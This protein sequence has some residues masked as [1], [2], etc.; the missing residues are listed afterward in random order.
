M[1]LIKY[2]LP[3][4]L[5]IIP[6]STFSQENPMKK[7]DDLLESQQPNAAQ[8]ELWK[9]IET[10]QAKNDHPTLIKAFPYFTR[11]LIPLEADERTELFENV[12][13]KTNELSEPSKSI[14]ELQLMQSLAYNFNIWFDYYGTNDLNDR[15][16]RHHFILER[17]QNLAQ[18]TSL[19]QSYRFKD[20][21]TALLTESKDTLYMYH[22]L[23]DYMAY[24]LIELYRSE[25]IRSGGNLKKLTTENTAWYSTATDFQ[26]LQFDKAS[27]TQSILGLYQIIEGN[28]KNDLN[29]LST[30]VYQRLQYL[31]STFNNKEAIKKAWKEEFDFFKQTAARSKFLFELAKIK[32]YKGKEYHY[33]NKPEVEGLIKEAHLQLTEEL[34]AF[35][36]TDFK[37]E[38]SGLISIIEHQE[39]K[40][41]FPQITTS[42]KKIPL[43]VSHRNYSTKTL[44]IYFMKEYDPSN[45]ISFREYIKKG[46]ANVVQTVNLELKNKDLFQERTTELLLDQLPQNGRYYI[47]A[48]DGAID[49]S[50]YAY[51]D[52]KW[53]DLKIS[54]SPFTISDIVA[55]STSANN[56][57]QVLVMDQKTGK[58]IKD[59]E[60]KIYYN[61]Y[62]RNLEGKIIAQGKTNQDGLFSVP[63]KENQSV[64][65]VVHYKDNVLKGARN[66]LYKN[67]NSKKIKQ[68]KLITDRSIYRPNQTV[69]FKGIAYEGKENEYSVSKG[70][71]VTITL[72]DASYQE[73][74]SE[75]FKTNEFGSIDGSIQIPE[76][77][78]LG[79]FT[80]IANST[81][82]GSNSSSISF[83]VEEYKRPTYEVKLNAPKEEAKLNDTVKVIG[84][85]KAFAGFPISNATVEYSI[86]R[87]WS[88][89]WRF[90]PGNSSGD[91]LT[92]GS[93]TT[94]Q[95]GDFE[96]KFF[97]ETDP[98]AER[99]AYYYYE[100]R[101][102]VTDLS[103]ETHETTLSLNLSDVGLALQVEMPNQWFTHEKGSIN[104]EIVNL[105]G[106][107]QEMKGAIELKIYKKINDDRFLNRIWENAEVNQFSPTDLKKTFPELYPNSRLDAFKTY[108]EEELIKTV[109]FQ[110]GKLD[111]EEVLQQ[112][113]NKQQGSYVFKFTY[114]IE[115]GDSLKIEK[116]VEVIDVK[117]KELPS[118]NNIWSFVSTHELEVGEDLDFQV[119]S[120]FKNA[121]ALISLYRGQELVSQHWAD[122]N[123]RYSICYT[124][125]EKDRGRLTYNAVLFHNGI[126]YT[127]AQT[128]NI[129]F[130]NKKLDIKTSVFRDKLLPGQEESWSFTIKNKDNQD[131][132]AELAAAMYDTSLDQIRGHGWDFWL[133]HASGIYNNWQNEWSQNIV[134]MGK[135]GMDY[136][137]QQIINRGSEKYNRILRE[138]FNYY[139]YYAYPSV[140]NF[141]S[142]AVRGSR[143]KFGSDSIVMEAVMDESTTLE[144]KE[145]ESSEDGDQNQSPAKPNAQPRENF[146][147]TA[148]FYPTI[149]ANEAEEYVLNFTLPESL[150]KWKLLMLAHNQAMQIGLL[151]KEIEAKKELMIT[152][153]A[154]RFVR[155]GDEIIFSSKVINLTDKEQVVEV[156]LLLEDLINNKELHLI[157]GVA[158]QMVTVPANSTQEVNWKLKI[159]NS[160]LLQYTVSASNDSFSDGERNYLPVLSNRT[161]V[162]ETDHILLKE[163]GSITHTFD[164]FKNQNSITLD[165]K[166]FSVEYIDNLAWEAVLA[167][168]YLSKTSDQSATSL[169]NSYYANALAK[170][171]V[172]QNPQ[173]E[174]IFKQW[175][176]ISP[177]V[178][179]SK[180][181]QNKELKDLLL[182]ETP[183][184][185]DAKD[186]GEQRRRIAVLFELN[187][188]Q[189]NQRS[190]FTELS[191][192]QNPDGGF[193]WFKGGKSNPWITQN[194]LTQ[195]GHLKRLKIDLTEANALIYKAEA[196]VT[197]KQIENYRKH[198]KEAKDKTKY[199]LSSSDVYW[200]YTR[201]FFSSNKS[202]EIDDLMHLYQEKLKKD[203]TKFNPYLQAL[204]GTYFKKEGINTA[205]AIYTSLLDRAKK[206]THLG[207]Y[208]VENSGYF[209][210]DN[211]ILTHAMITTF[212]K[213]MGAKEEVIDDAL[214]WLILNKESSAWSTGSETAEAIYAI[215]FA[216]KDYLKP[217][218]QPQI[219][220]GNH[221]FVYE[222]TKGK[223]EIQVEWT[224][225]LGQV[226]HQWNGT[227][228][229]PNLGVVE[230]EKFSDAPAVLNM[231]WQYTEDLSK[232]KGS[233]NKSMQIT[234]TYRKLV[235]GDKK[236]KGV[237]AS[238]FKVGDKIEIELLVTVDRDMDFV[239]IKDLRPAGFE[240]VM[241][242]S[243]YRW[244]SG[245]SY[246]QSPK[247]VSMDYFVERMYKGTYKFTYTVYATHGGKFNSGM[248]SIQSFY[249]P[250]FS[251][252]SGT[253]NVEIEK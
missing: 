134:T 174:K 121:K 29:Y 109:Q 54:Y 194:I 97:A 161:W 208:W 218:P 27:L 197:T 245:L 187:Q 177:D 84:N 141:R 247:D 108:P 40:L 129:P 5:F 239:H 12:L 3:I 184:V 183:W 154:P 30:A 8:K 131:I 1:K 115:D 31:N 169:V 68:I 107:K 142:V 106:E 35:P 80:L 223:N 219:K 126:F 15:E 168:P 210:Y 201:T 79:N 113:L 233:D 200:L 163:K 74:Y 7:I 101:A 9:V 241:S 246:Y 157:E 243:G 18:K 213:D 135:Y 173:I 133:Y 176:S 21:E 75:E 166:S 231:Y 38:I 182:S 26:T 10:A 156:T 127:T 114:P 23:G 232:I 112:F 86:Y 49:L 117:A 216:G 244:E 207:M 221:A 172:S 58:P 164:A 253:K 76:G 13:N 33:K 100:V 14:T 167:L 196:Y 149:Y 140:E 37:G 64:Y 206:N 240:P 193:A 209:W 195:F 104:T 34:K 222:Q 137:L 103:G 24:Q 153:N 143:A 236:E 17:M 42:D 66:Y 89:F 72:R 205:D 132:P 227:E 62:L 252:H 48:T 204:I 151:Q 41:S 120:S 186:E 102:K 185:I 242:T 128:V 170:H 198:L 148:F 171:I 71:N 159:D 28:N 51:S 50:D 105:S 44:R 69:Y 39:F 93:I 224:P 98:N 94:N 85:A 144:K 56:K 47:V 111:V 118:P 95:D 61:G 250:K 6:F 235:P 155:Q 199:N 191:Q 189:N 119:G 78:P 90:Y 217:S 52:T 20:F 88:R 43:L 145:S 53:N 60:V 36:N 230:I 158:T 2:F 81:V 16:T 212:L 214:L 110:G 248:A 19:L 188:L 46:K 234:K 180:L 123:K 152:P 73:I 181:E 228:I 147:E 83:N 165:N 139:D 91:K 178:F 55:V 203:W 77:V 190:L 192:R 32:Y 146:D 162:T 220:V 237:L 59:A 87:N 11:V 25:I 138:S 215:L 202:K 249:A 96:I 225:G 136:Q 4:L 99:F 63:I 226:K 70:I 229:N 67:A 82:K 238:E 160:E 45:E 150:T 116:E 57:H 92:E 22:S 124:V 175:Q 211:K 65:Y 125:Q 122:V 179:L 130:S 251:G